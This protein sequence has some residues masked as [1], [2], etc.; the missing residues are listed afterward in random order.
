VLM[1]AAQLQVQ[2]RRQCI[3]LRCLNLA[4]PDTGGSLLSGIFNMKFPIERGYPSGLHATIAPLWVV[5]TKT[6]IQRQ[7]DPIAT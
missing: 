7:V 2:V 5:C 3:G 4:L 1:A 6:T